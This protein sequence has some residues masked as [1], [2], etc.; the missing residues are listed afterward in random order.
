MTEEP[1]HVVVVRPV[2]SQIK[3]WVGECTCG[4]ETA[5]RSRDAVEAFM[6][7]CRLKAPTPKHPRGVQ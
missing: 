3:F 1:L 2:H 4:R 5:D 7:D 6:A